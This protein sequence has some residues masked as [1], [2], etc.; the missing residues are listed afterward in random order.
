MA[1]RRNAIT[2]QW[3]ARSI[4]MLENPA[5]RTLSLSA[6]RALARI[7]IELAHHGGNDNGRLPVTFDD[8]VQYGVRRRFNWVLTG[9][10]GDARFHQNHT[11]R[12]DGQRG[13]I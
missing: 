3:A 6:H 5:Y 13:R 1:K 11:A 7:E 2:G 10:I 9:G 12:K 8:F 4:E